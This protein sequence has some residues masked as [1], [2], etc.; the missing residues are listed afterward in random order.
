MR[1]S[2]KLTILFVAFFSAVKTFS[3]TLNFRHYSVNDGLANSTVYYIFQDSRDFIWIATESGVNRFD[4]NKFELFTMDNG[5]SDNEVLQIHEDSAGRIWFLTLNGNLSYFFNERF[6]NTS[7]DPWL[8]KSMGNGSLTSFYQDSSS[9]LWF[10]TNQNKLIQIDAQKNIRVFSS[11]E[12]SLLNAFVW[13]T[14]QKDLIAFSEKYFFKLSKE[15]FIPVPLNHYPLSPKAIFRDNEKKNIV[16]LSAGGLMQYDGYKVQKTGHLL[17]KSPSLIS[18]LLLER[19]HIWIG[20]MGTGLLLYNSRNQISEVHLKNLNISH[21]LKDRQGNLWISTIGDGIY[22]LPYQR[23]FAKHITKSDGLSADAITSILKTHNKI[24]LGYNNGS[25][26]ILKGETVENMLSRPVNNYDPVRKLH[27]EAPAG[28]LWYASD[29]SLLK[30]HGKG[31]QLNLLNDPKW[32]RY[33]LKSFSLDNKKNLAVAMAS[34]VYILK[35]QER[36]QPSYS[37]LSSTSR[38]LGRAFAVHFDRDGGLWF[39]NIRGLHYLKGKS[40]IQLYIKYPQLR[41]RIT[42]IATLADNTIICSSYG[43]GIFVLKDGKLLKTI[44]TRDGLP[45]NICKKLFVEGKNAWVVTGKGISKVNLQGDIPEVNNYDTEKGLLSNEVNDIYVEND[46]AYIASNIGLTIF[47][48]ALKPEKTSLP[49]VLIRSVSVNN[50]PSGLEKIK[51]LSYTENN[52][53]VTYI[54]MDYANPQRV[55]YSYRTNQNESWIETNEQTIEFSSLKPGRYDL[56]IRA[57]SMY[58]GWTHPTKIHFNIDEPLWM[59]WWFLSLTVASAIFLL[60]LLVRRYYRTKQIMEKEK[61]V[62]K[63]RLISLEQQALQAMM[64][65]HFIFNVMNSIQYFINTRDNAMANQVLTGFARLI[66]KNLDICNKSY[67][68]IQEEIT[69]LGL[70]LSLEKLRFGEKMSY[71]ITTNT[72]IDLADTYIPSM[73]LQPYV[74]N[75]IWHGIMPMSEPG[76]INVDI[77]SAEHNLILTIRDNGVGIDE[78]L[79]S[80]SSDHISRGMQLTQQR[81]ALMNKFNKNAMS[82]SVSQQATGGTMVTVKIPLKPFTHS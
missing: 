75:A 28:S 77:I 20:T 4:G 81:I 62:T 23:N 43:F 26:D 53:S 69:Y 51:N 58:T 21:I 18:G 57:K 68:S 64:N 25:L 5:L 35:D 59:R 80:K 15:G 16:F 27:E 9:R 29:N 47:K 10:S 70:Y 48:E 31:K 65:P 41:H 50:K 2:V 32:S 3:T 33:A 71:S 42:D 54:C 74:E 61:L 34:G 56:E 24:L 37:D 82:I 79:K 49:P 38:F 46:T 52:V 78:S 40:L 12:H 39:S 8:K 76:E 17:Q 7:T 19:N 55:M 22:L 72:D 44:T 30:I 45:S 66:R 73:L 63:T 67:I 60:F 36:D 11:S 13:E 14:P 1:S 6:F